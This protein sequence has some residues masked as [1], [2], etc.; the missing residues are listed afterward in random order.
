MKNSYNKIILNVYFWFFC[1]YQL[2]TC[3]FWIVCSF[4]DKFILNF[5]HFLTLYIHFQLLMVMK[6]TVDLIGKM[7]FIVETFLTSWLTKT[8]FNWFWLIH[9]Y[10]HHIRV[11]ET[12]FLPLL[13]WNLIL[14]CM[15][16]SESWIFS[17][18]LLFGTWSII[19]SQSLIV[20]YWC[21]W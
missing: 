14:N 1:H 20:S 9:W 21:S 16:K 18:M 15:I 3:C 11:Y 5:F 19:V 6:M 10:L 2:I 8:V 13:V 7:F 17:L 12:R 4:L